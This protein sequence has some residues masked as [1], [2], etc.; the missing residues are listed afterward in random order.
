MFHR[1]FHFCF[2]QPLYHTQARV[3]VEVNRMKTWKI[4][5]VAVIAL[6]AAGLLTASAFAY[7]GGHGFSPYGTNTN[8]GYTTYPGGM[9]GGGH[10]GGMMGGYG[11]GTTTPSTSS[12]QYGWGCHGSNGYPYAP[13]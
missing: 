8:G 3:F 2:S 6:V 1:L 5:T 9:M 4:I 10:M 13:N 7:M 11:Y 12:G